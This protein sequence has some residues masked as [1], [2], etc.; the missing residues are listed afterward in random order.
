MILSA[1]SAWTA[2]N[3]HAV[4]A[5]KD[6][7]PMKKRLEKLLLFYIICLVAGASAVL[8][9]MRFGVGV[10]CFFYELTGLKCPGCGMTHSVIALLHGD[11]LGASEHNMAFYPEIVYMAWVIIYGSVK[12]VREDKIFCLP[13]PVA[14]HVIFAL[15]LAGWT[16]ARNVLG[17]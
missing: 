10:P 1:A 6:I 7:M 2:E 13:P 12:F 5:Q 3:V 9:Y 15:L 17:I 11:I 16:A 4:F 14:V 8:V